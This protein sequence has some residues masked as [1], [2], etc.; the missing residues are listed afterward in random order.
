[1]DLTKFMQD[2]KPQKNPFR[3]PGASFGYRIESKADPIIKS[4][5]PGSYDINPIHPK[6]GGNK[7]PQTTRF[8]DI[9]IR[10]NLPGPGAYY[11]DPLSA[12]PHLGKGPVSPRDLSGGSAKLNGTFSKAQRS[13]IFTKTDILVGPGQYP[14]KR[15]FEDLERFKKVQIKTDQDEPKLPAEKAFKFFVLKD[16]PGP[17]QYNLPGALSLSPKHPAGFS[18]G[19]STRK[20]IDDKSIRKQGL[21]DDIYYKYSKHDL[22]GTEGPKVGFGI[23]KRS[24]I[25]P[26]KAGPGPAAYSPGPP[27]EK[28]N[29]KGTFGH[30]KRI[31]N[32]KDLELGPGPGEYNLETSNVGKGPKIGKSA[33]KTP[34]PKTINPGPGQ[35]DILDEFEEKKREA[36]KKLAAYQNMLLNRSSHF[37]STDDLKSPVHK[38][39]STEGDSSPSNL[40]RSSYR[41]KSPKRSQYSKA[42]WVEEAIKAS[43]SPGPK[44]MSPIDSIEGK[45]GYLG[46]KFSDMARP[47]FAG[48][49]IK[50][51]I[52]GPGEYYHEK[53]EDEIKQV[54]FSSSKRKADPFP[55]AYTLGLPGPSQY[56]S[57]LKESIF[58][59]S[60]TKAVRPA[61]EEKSP[62]P[63]NTPKKRRPMIGSE[64]NID[65]KAFK[66]N[67][68]EKK[69]SSKM[70]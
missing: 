40:M 44:Y 56:N 45:L 10:K 60:F 24:D 20:F 55:P 22:M 48:G 34:D 9:T 39:L 17:G 70:I 29:V 25:S 46:T 11:I 36:D 4:V 52:P 62:S 28:Q 13:G 37:M 1:M 67:S 47:E 35:Y 32:A 30:A 61:A 42:N 68:K 64:T 26:Q 66:S 38:A 31:L 41:D 49:E 19:T 8:S 57:T 18:I 50:K 6:Y 15:E 63:S 27:R 65:G 2:I 3:V 58:G 16:T 14:V 23:G 5:G 53:E 51:R 69:G 43:F 33:K 21:N 12:S 7:F 54:S 59:G